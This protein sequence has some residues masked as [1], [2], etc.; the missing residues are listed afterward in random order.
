MGSLI[1]WTLIGATVGFT[2]G[3]IFGALVMFLWRRLR[4]AELRAELQVLR[5]QASP[6][7]MRDHLR[8][9]TGDAM[10]DLVEITQKQFD[11]LLKRLQEQAQAHG[12]LKEELDR[13]FQT[14]GEL[15]K[16]TTEVASALKASIP[17]GRWAEIQL[18]RLVELAGMQEYVDVE[19]Q[20]SLSEGSRPDLV[21]RLPND[22]SIAVDAKAPMDAY[23]R[24]VEATDVR[25]RKKHLEDHAKALKNHIRALSS[26]EYWRSLGNPGPEFVVMY[27]PGEPILSA[28]FEGDHELLE[29]AFQQRVLLAT[30]VIFLAL[31]KVIAYGWQQRRAL[32]NAQAIMEQSQELSR[33]LSRFVEH[34]SDL[35][36]ELKQA[37]EKYNAAL[38][39][40]ERRVRPAF[41]KM[42]RLR[43]TTEEINAPEPIE[44]MPR[45]LFDSSGQ[46]E[47]QETDADES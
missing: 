14:I 5:G 9:I 1:G 22:C 25:E 7:A 17:R 4:E 35:G 29:F 32:E 27:I 37:V 34:L 20:T 44:E 16:H 36:R 39:S 8:A 19:F 18:Q 24:A 43:G 3:F 46:G 40:F 11:P 33:R 41:E 47:G 28:A 15:Q 23:L 6:E 42:Q 30:P 12:A 13:L 21:V 26:K 45:M 2:L 31:L 10:K 38:G